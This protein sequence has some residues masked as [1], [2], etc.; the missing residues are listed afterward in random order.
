MGGSFVSSADTFTIGEVEPVP[1]GL[2]A[3]E[4]F[5]PLPRTA[6]GGADLAAYAIE[7]F[8]QRPQIRRAGEIVLPTDVLHP[9][10]RGCGRRGRW[11]AIR[12][13]V[14]LPWGIAC[15][16]DELSGAPTPREYRHDVRRTPSDRQEARNR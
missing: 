10:L 1:G 13:V 6:E 2:Y 4:T 9:W 14:E 8:T 12:G 3:E 11:S 16:H 5:G 7:R 15:L